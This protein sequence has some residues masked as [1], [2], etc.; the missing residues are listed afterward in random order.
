MHGTYNEKPE[1]QTVKAKIAPNRVKKV[2][3]TLL[4][5]I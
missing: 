3:K 5:A 1:L 4:K 2:R